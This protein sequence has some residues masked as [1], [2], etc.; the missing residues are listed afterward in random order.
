MRLSTARGSTFL[1]MGDEDFKDVVDTISQVIDGVG[2]FVIVVGL[3]IASGIFLAHLRDASRRASTYLVYRQQ[4]GK[5]IL[6]G[7]EF[8][9]A[10]DIVRTVAIDPTFESVGVLGLLVVVRT[11]LSF[12]LGLE[13]EGRWPWQ[14]PPKASPPS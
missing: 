9:V 1:L 5:T 6:L 12:T 13:I 8:L 7:L 11:F 3:I 2:I 10:A 14:G 4:V